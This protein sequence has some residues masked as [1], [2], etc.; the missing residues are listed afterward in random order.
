[1]ASSLSSS[2]SS[3]D[4]IGHDAAVSVT[5]KATTRPLPPRHNP[6]YTGATNGVELV[7]PHI[8][9]PVLLTT[10]TGEGL[11][12]FSSPTDSHDDGGVWLKAHHRQ[13]APITTSAAAVLVGK[14]H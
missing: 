8:A 6:S 7:V 4:Y 9:A 1:M 13:S 2:A 10:A 12:S 11:A 5:T 14:T 3:S